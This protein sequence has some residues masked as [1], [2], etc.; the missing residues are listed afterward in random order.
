MIADPCLVTGAY[1]FLGR[2]VARLLAASGHRVVGLGHGSWGRT[3]WSEWGLASWHPTDVT[4]DALVTYG[5]E[6]GAIVHCAGGASVAFS[7]AHPYEDF[8]R[9]VDSTAAVLEFARLHARGARVVLASSAG[10]YGEVP[11]APIPESAPCT[12]V[13]PYGAHK[14]MAEDL[15]RSFSKGGG[16][17]TAVVRLFSVYGPGLRKQLLWDACERLAR[18]ENSFFGTGGEVRDWLHVE[19]AA[20]LLVAALESA[21]ADCPVF[22]GGTGVGTSV[23]DVLGTLFEALG[24]T[25][26][27]NFS[28]QARTGDPSTLVADASRAFAVGWRPTYVWQDGISAFAAWHLAGAR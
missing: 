18:G 19:D 9:T 4:L 7:M 1:G 12:P 21:S 24:R 2:H 10:V 14:K 13:S 17:S 26:K 28:A 6:P 8:R 15:C 20:A 11:A 23:R 25:D 5:N 22:N 16:L 3:E 27:P